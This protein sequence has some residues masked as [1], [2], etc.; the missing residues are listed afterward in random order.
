[1]PV[2]LPNVHAG[3]LWPSRPGTSMLPGVEPFWQHSASQAVELQS[4]CKARLNNVQALVL[5]FLLL[6]WLSLIAV[7]VVAPD[8]YDQALRLLSSGNAR[9]AELLFLGALSAFVLLIAVGVLR[10]WRW[11]FWLLLVAFVS[12]I[13]RQH[14]HARA[15]LE[16]MSNAGEGSELGDG[17]EHARV[18]V[19]DAEPAGQ[20]ARVV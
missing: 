3:R 18:G 4:M 20:G 8:V 15:E 17:V 1:V 14:Q 13:L 9:Q 11:A 19:D 6:A 2:R 7:L 12:G 10:R 16:T 5:G